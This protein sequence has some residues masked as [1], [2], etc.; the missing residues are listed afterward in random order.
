[1]RFVARPVVSS[2]SPASVLLAILAMA[3]CTLAL[4]AEPAKSKSQAPKAE[5]AKS[6]RP[7]GSVEAAESKD[8]AKSTREDTGGLPVRPE[9]WKW[10]DACSADLER[11]CSSSPAPP[12]ACLYQKEQELSDECWKAFI[13][14]GRFD[15][16]LADLN[17]FCRRPSDLPDCI[18]RNEKESWET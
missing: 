9:S 11:L 13:K 4:A 15:V 16:C 1:M 14:P 10:R 6:K 17:K 2:A 5:S 18:R 12:R 8:P 3:T 7:A